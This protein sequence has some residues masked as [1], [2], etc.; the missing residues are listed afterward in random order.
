VQIPNETLWSAIGL[1][2]MIIGWLVRLERRLNERMTRREHSDVCDRVNGELKDKI[3]ELRNLIER[4][5][6][7]AL[8]HRSLVGDSLASIRMQV[9]VIRD[10]MGD[11]PLKEASGSWRRD[12]T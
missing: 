10:R 4:Q 7:Q 11:D 3:Q 12:R 2:A 1:L 5:N 8:L 6:E 9:A